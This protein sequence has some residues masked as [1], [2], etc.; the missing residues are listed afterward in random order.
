M[1]AKE[2][3]EKYKDLQKSDIT[4]DE[5][6]ALIDAMFKELLD[7][8]KKGGKFYDIEEQEKDK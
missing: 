2:Y 7:N 8:Y 1:K 5:N 6:R 4:P 3:A